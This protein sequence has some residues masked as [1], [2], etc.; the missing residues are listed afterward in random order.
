[1]YEVMFAMFLLTFGFSF[2]L[3]VVGGMMKE[4]IDKANKKIDEISKKLDD[5][6]KEKWK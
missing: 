4:K 3:I 1:M 2:V 5:L 6:G